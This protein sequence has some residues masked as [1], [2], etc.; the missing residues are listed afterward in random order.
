MLA[1]SPPHPKPSA[2]TSPR[3]R[4]EVKQTS[5]PIQLKAIVSYYCEVKEPMLGRSG[6]GGRGTDENSGSAGG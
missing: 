2:S 5:V 3:L 6:I 4:R 1:D